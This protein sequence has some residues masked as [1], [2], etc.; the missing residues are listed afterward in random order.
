MPLLD[1]LAIT[2]E[3]V[4][5]TKNSKRLANVVIS[6]LQVED[7]KAHGGAVTMKINW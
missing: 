1:Q 5:T 6:L 2:L 4:R 3:L 7:S